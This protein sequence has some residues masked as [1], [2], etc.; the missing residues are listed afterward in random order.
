MKYDYIALYNK[1]AKFLNARP[2]LKRAVKLGNLFFTALFVV[3]YGV[4]SYLVLTQDEFDPKTKLAVLFV[5][6][7]AFLIVSILRIAIECPRPYAENGAG[8]QPLAEKKRADKKSFPS[9]HL[10]CAAVIAVVCLKFLPAVGVL[11][12]LTSLALAYTRFALGLHYPSDL[13]V[14]EGI[15]LLIGCFIF[16]L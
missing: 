11:L 16:I 2:L 13:L 14:G 5:P 7:L 8:I 12:L 4:L 9:R 3:C 10:T 1:N 15:G 6:A